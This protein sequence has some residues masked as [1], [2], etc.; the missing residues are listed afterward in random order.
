MY[1]YSIFLTI[2]LHFPYS[3]QLTYTHPSQTHTQYVDLDYEGGGIGEYQ[4]WDRDTQSYNDTA[5]YYAEDGSG[6]GDNNNGD[7]AAD[8]QYARS[9]SRCAKM[10]CHEPDT[11]W[12]VLGFFKHRN[13]DDWMEQLFKHEGMC[14]WNDEEYAFMK[15][16]RKAWPKDVSIRDQP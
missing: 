10:D 3:T 2:P 6:S 5:C 15:N 11:N 12:S 8:D 9:K 13:Y 7:D 1:I 4:Y 16:A 14:V